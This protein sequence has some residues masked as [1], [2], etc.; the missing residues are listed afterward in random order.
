M[1][2]TQAIARINK[3]DEQKETIAVGIFP[4]TLECDICHKHPK[5][6]FPDVEL[7][8]D[9]C[10]ECAQLIDRIRQMPYEIFIKLLCASSKE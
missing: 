7:G 10:A 4:K 1:D 5:Y 8:V 9:V 3:A 6:I 2:K